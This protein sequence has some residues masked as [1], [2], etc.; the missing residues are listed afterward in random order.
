ME[1]L[2]RSVADEPPQFPV[3]LEISATQPQSQPPSTIPPTILLDIMSQYPDLEPT[4]HGLRMMVSVADQ[5][6][7]HGKSSSFWEDE[8][9]A[10][11]IIGPATHHFLSTARLPNNHNNNITSVTSVLAEEVRIVCLILL[12]SL[13]AQFSLSSADME[14]LQDKVA[15]LSEWEWEW[16]IS[17]LDMPLARLHL[18]AMV[19]LCLSV[20]KSVSRRTIAQICKTSRILG[21]DSGQAAVYSAKDLVWIDAIESSKA[22]RL[23][24]EVTVAYT[25]I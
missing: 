20:H 3:P 18:W 16:D 19:T 22:A 4:V 17:H 8:T 7:T 10:I 13:K 5:V 12:S 6:N 23:V 1:I 21:I 11:H 2:G 15:L 25:T 9:T 14:P 24:E